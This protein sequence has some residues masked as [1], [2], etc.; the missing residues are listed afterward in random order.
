MPL[1]KEWT[2]AVIIKGPSNQIVLVKN[3]SKPVPHFW[4]F[5]GGRKEPGE[6]AEETAVREIQEETGLIIYK[7]KL[8]SEESRGNHWFY[9]FEVEV[10]DFSHLKSIGED[11]EI[12]SL[13]PNTEINNMVDFFPPHRDILK[14]IIYVFDETP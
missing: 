12:V 11:G 4:K 8:L 1:V 3:E 9:L 10:D 13:F 6:T 7:P 14:R 2:A 5:P